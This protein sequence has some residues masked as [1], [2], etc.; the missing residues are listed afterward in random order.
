[1]GRLHGGQ[2]SRELFLFVQ[3]AGTIF[4]SW[5]VIVFTHHV[6]ASER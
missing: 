4:L 1:M 2:M 3:F 5:C 6:D